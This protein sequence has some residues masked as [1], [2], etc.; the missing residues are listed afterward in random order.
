[1]IYGLSMLMALFALVF[2][3]PALRALQRMRAIRASGMETLGRVSEKSG[4]GWLW[5]ASFGNQERLQVTYQPERGPEMVFGL[6][7]SSVLPLRRYQ[8]G[9]AVTV[10]YD[11]TMPGEA[12][13]KGEWQVACRDGWMALGGLALAVLFLTLG[14]L[15]V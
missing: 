9:Q 3:I 2:G 1:M 8:P 15:G 6:N 10:I 4:T 14:L 12:Y 7:T 5:T 13:V 11:R